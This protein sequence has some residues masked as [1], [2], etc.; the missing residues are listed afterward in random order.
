MKNI[1]I[2]SLVV[3]L[4]IVCIITVDKRIN[5]LQDELITAKEEMAND[6]ILV[7]QYQDAMYQFMY[8]SP[9][10]AHKFEQLLEN[11]D[12]NDEQN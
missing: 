1:T 8:T 9:D 4:V 3:C 2:A 5:K 6:S 12:L 7:H 11:K 10:C